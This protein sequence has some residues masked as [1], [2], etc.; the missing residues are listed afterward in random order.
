[1]LAEELAVLHADTSFW[2]SVRPL[3]EI[4]LRLEQNDISYSW[5][6]WKKSQLD[7]FLACLPAHCALVVGVWEMVADQSEHEVLALSCV[8][9]VVEGAVCSLRTFEALTTEGL[10]PVQELEPGY[11][12]ALEIMRAARAQVAPVAWALFTDRATWDEWLYTG[13]EADCDSGKGEFLT[14]LAHSGRCVILGSQAK[15]H[16]L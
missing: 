1:V 13:S 7:A 16:H 8:C 6:G 10:L 4:A 11:G 15:H 12:H 2:D 9:E 3:L 5:Y 14:R